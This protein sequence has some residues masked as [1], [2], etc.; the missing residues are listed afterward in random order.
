MSTHHSFFILLL[1]LPDFSDTANFLESSRHP[2]SA[3]LFMEPG[4]FYLDY[5]FFK[6]DLVLPATPSSCS[7]A[8]S[9]SS[10]CTEASLS[11]IFGFLFDLSF[12]NF[13]LSLFIDELDLSLFGLFVLCFIDPKTI[14]SSCTSLAHK[15]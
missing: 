6:F 15:E 9:F 1:L 8:L 2:S 13:E 4:D 3:F 12:L 10:K 5:R 14:S 11:L 7:E